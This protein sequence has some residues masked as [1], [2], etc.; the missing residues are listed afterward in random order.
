MLDVCTP[1]LLLRITWCTHLTSEYQVTPPEYRAHALTFGMSHVHCSGGV[2]VLW[3]TICH[4]WTS[5]CVRMC[6]ISSV[7]FGTG[8]QWLLLK[9]HS[10]HACCSCNTPCRSIMLDGMSNL[11][12]PHVFVCVNCSMSVASHIYGV[13]DGVCG[14][15]VGWGSTSFATSC[16]L[17]L[18]SKWGHMTSSGSGKYK[19]VCVCVCARVCVRACVCAHVCVRASIGSQQPANLM[20]I[21]GAL[22]IRIPQLALFKIALPATCCT[23]ESVILC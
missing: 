1:V 9:H 5:Y 21:G 3:C 13:T 15:G 20:W 19:C 22:Y 6:P 16:W 14:G 18:A 12:Y 4:L 2:C 8:C 23:Q 10:W 17:L 7:W 11:C